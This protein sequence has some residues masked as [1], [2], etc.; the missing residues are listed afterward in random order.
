M[1]VFGHACSQDEPVAA[2]FG[3][4]AGSQ[5]D[6]PACSA[7]SGCKLSDSEVSRQ[8]E[9]RVEYIEDAV[10][11]E[12]PLDRNGGI[13]FL[14]QSESALSGSSV[15]D[16]G[17]NLNRERLTARIAKTTKETGEETSSGICSTTSPV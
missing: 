17:G 11:Y 14:F 3:H 6:C 15:E 12:I 5:S 9:N 4:L 2:V 13:F 16:D 7:E 10:F 8:A 1:G